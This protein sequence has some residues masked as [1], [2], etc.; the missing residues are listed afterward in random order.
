[1]RFGARL[2][3][4]ER[5][6]VMRD[7]RAVLRV[8]LERRNAY[9][10]CTSEKWHDHNFTRP[11]TDPGLGYGGYLHIPFKHKSEEWEPEGEFQTQDRL[12][13]IWRIGDVL[14]DGEIELGVAGVTP[15]LEE[16]AWEWRLDVRHGER[17]R[18]GVGRIWPVPNDPP[19]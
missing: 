8:P 14:K 15:V 16:G 6:A 7:G 2:S 9:W 5:E 18:E 13:C 17:V 12:R 1:M 19:R 4:E 11:R 10:G 3:P